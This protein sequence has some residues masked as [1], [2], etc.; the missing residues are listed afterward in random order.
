MSLENRIEPRMSCELCD[1]WVTIA[2]KQDG[3][4]V[5]KECDKRFPRLKALDY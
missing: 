2:S 3:I 4:W 5:C 1:E